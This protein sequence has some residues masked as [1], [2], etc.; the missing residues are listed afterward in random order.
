VIARYLMDNFPTF[1]SQGVSMIDTRAF[2]AFS[3]S[4][5]II[6]LSKQFNNRSL[7]QRMPAELRGINT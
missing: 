3:K 5:S 7:F 6:Y 2:S 4:K 1:Q